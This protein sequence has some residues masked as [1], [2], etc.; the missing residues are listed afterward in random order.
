MVLA[1]DADEPISLPPPISAHPVRERGQGRAARAERRLRGLNRS[2]ELCPSV[3]RFYKARPACTTVQA[4]SWRQGCCRTAC[5]VD[6]PRAARLLRGG[7]AGDAAPGRQSSARCS[8]G[9]Q[10]QA[11]SSRPPAGLYS[12]LQFASTSAPA[13]EAREGRGEDESV[14]K[15]DGSQRRQHR[16]L[17]VQVRDMRAAEER[18]RLPGPG[19]S[20]VSN[21]ASREAFET[22]WAA[23]GPARERLLVCA[24]LSAARPASR[25]AGCPSQTHPNL[26]QLVSLSTSCL[27]VAC[28]R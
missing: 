9:H 16:A 1:L 25:P 19:R 24:R 8:P 4:G 13:R 18:T 27:G 2:R 23:S 5:G 10:L 22:C 21:W 15:P 6:R 17:Q 26:M 11:A 3:C 14:P 28:L 20:N 7:G 12:R